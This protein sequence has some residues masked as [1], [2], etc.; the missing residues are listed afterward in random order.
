[1]LRFSTN[2]LFYLTYCKLGCMFCFVKFCN[3]LNLLIWILNC[4]KCSLPSKLSLTCGG[5][6][7]H[8]K[9]VHHPI[10]TCGNREHPGNF[11]NKLVSSPFNWVSRYFLF[12]AKCEGERKDFFEGCKK[13]ENIVRL[14]PRALACHKRWKSISFCEIGN[15]PTPPLFFVRAPFK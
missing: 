2:L 14:L 4:S 5:N 13:G 8:Y 10:P 15:N 11:Q 9:N 1:M 12:L 3:F 7:N 6:V